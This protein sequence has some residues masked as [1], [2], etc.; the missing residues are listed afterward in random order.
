[1]GPLSGRRNRDERV[2]GGWK[3]SGSDKAR[4]GTDEPDRQ[5]TASPS[6]GRAQEERGPRLE[7]W[8]RVLVGL[9]LNRQAGS[10]QRSLPASFVCIVVTTAW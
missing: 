8:F 1:M 2:N 7:L 9:D 4:P 6:L 5:F 3:I 10:W